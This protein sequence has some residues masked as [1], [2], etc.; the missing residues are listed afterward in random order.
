MVEE[1]K[2]LLSEFEE[3]KVRF[4]RRSANRVADSLAKEGCRNKVCNTW[5][6][7]PP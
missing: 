1:I 4:V 7:V 6:G 2:F 5:M 3:A